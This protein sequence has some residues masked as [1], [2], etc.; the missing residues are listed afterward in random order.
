MLFRCTRN[1]PSKKPPHQ[2]RAD[3][4]PRV[5]PRQG[6]TDQGAQYD[7]G[8][9]VINLRPLGSCDEVLGQNIV[10]DSGMNLHA[11]VHGAEWCAPQ[12]LDPHGSSPN[13]HDAVFECTFGDLA[14]EN[15]GDGN[16]GKSLRWAQ[17]IS[18][19]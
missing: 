10:D 11:G 18:G 4:A 1:F 6:N 7:D 5:H 17:V 19:H 3:G 9:Q 8:E 12:V 13:Q 16:M 2:R 14:L 15:V